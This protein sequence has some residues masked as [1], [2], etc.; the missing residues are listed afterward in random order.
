MINAYLDGSLLEDVKEE[1]ECEL[2]DDLDGLE[3]EEAAVLAM[4]QKRLAFDLRAQLEAGV[5]EAQARRR[6]SG[7]A[8]RSQIENGPVTSAQNRLS[9][10]ARQA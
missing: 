8:E 5:A 3:P 4:L 9:R 10:I 7:S 6:L 2:R 1:V